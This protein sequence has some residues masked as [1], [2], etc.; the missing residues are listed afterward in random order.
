LN[1]K[2]VSMSLTSNLPSSSNDPTAHLRAMQL[3]LSTVWLK[4][5]M[6]IAFRSLW[7]L[8]NQTLRE[9]GPAAVILECLMDMVVTNVQTF[10]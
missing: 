9:D 8:Q 2:K 3:T 1:K 6:K 4:T 5:T 10:W 7:I